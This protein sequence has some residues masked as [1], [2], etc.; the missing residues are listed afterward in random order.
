[1]GG[2]RP[3]FTRSTSGPVTSDQELFASSKVLQT[4]RSA[5]DALATWALASRLAIEPRRMRDRF[6][7]LV[8]EHRLAFVALVVVVAS[9]VHLLL[10]VFA[11]RY[12]FPHRAALL[13]PSA[14]LAG[15]VLTLLGR[16]GLIAAWRA[17]RSRFE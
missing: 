16:R 12:P 17:R 2:E 10:M 14:V 13:L 3:A 15:G 7:A 5:V 11:Q 4:L 8:P 1:M 9:S 6:D